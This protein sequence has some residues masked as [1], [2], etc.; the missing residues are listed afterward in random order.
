MVEISDLCYFNH[1]TNGN[2]KLCRNGA[3]LR[4]C[5]FYQCSGTFKCPDLYC[6]P[7]FKFCDGTWDCTNG[8][9][10]IK[11]KV[12]NSSCIYLFVNV[13]LLYLQRNLV[14]SIKNLKLLNLKLLDV[15]N[16]LVT[17]LKGEVFKCLISL[18]MLNIVQ[19]PLV[20]VEIDIFETVQHLMLKTNNK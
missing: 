1:D 18:Q 3:H 15:S 14:Q 20:H 19:N 8:E 4:N 7:Y 13:K 16:N 9:D 10:E 2:L 17:Y 12:I 5:S 6:V 11:I